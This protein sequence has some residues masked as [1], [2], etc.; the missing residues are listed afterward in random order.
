MKNKIQTFS[1]LSLFLCFCLLVGNGYVA[2]MI[3]GNVW[4]V[5]LAELISFLLP[6]VLLYAT[7]KKSISFSRFRIKKLPKGAISLTIFCGL[8]IAIGSLFLNMLMYQFFGMRQ[9]DF[10]T[11]LIANSETGLSAVQKVLIVVVVSSIAEEV[12]LRGTLFSAQENVAGTAACI[13]FSGVSFAMLHGNILNFLGPFLAGIIYAYLTYIFDSI[14][15]AILAHAIN[16][17][18]Y[19]AILWLTQTYAAFGIWNYFSFLN[20]ILFLLFTYI[21]LRALEKMFE[22][23]VVKKFVRRKGVRDAISICASPAILAFLIAFIVKVF[24]YL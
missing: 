12:F 24:L 21:A 2:S 5:F 18:Y 9:A 8:A 23:K 6:C 7:N 19:L 10:S 17:V 4:V 1:G 11:S 13:V 22:R 14:Y 15:P 16:N 20:L 3:S